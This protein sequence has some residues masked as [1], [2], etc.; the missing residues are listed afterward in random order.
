M[1]IGIKC[2]V[3]LTVIFDCAASDNPCSISGTAGK[4]ITK[5][6]NPDYCTCFN[7]FIHELESSNPRPAQK[8]KRME[9][10]CHQLAKQ[11]LKNVNA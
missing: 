6:S 5:G 11:E 3:K 7:E 2:G 10:E 9:K 4:E 8:K 1:T